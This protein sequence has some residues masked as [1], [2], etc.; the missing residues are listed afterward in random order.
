MWPAW[1]RVKFYVKLCLVNVKMGHPWRSVHI[2]EDNI[3]MILRK[4]GVR[5]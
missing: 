2:K 5:M 3:K 1:Q 4:Y